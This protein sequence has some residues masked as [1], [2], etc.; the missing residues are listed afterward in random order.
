MMDRSIAQRE[1]ERIRAQH[2]GH[3]QAEH[4]VDAARPQNSVLHPHFEWDD[5]R[6]GEQYRLIQARQLIKIVI[7]PQR[8]SSETVVVPFYVNEEKGDGYVSIVE[9]MSDKDRAFNNVVQAITRAISILRNC[10]HK[11]AQKL[12]HALEKQRDQ[13]KP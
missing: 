7:A 5:S 8:V 4:V 2:G 6:A 10:P 1:L 13:L 11:T 12:A 9:V 3:L